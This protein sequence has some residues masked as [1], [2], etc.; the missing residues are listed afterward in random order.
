MSLGLLSTVR[1]GESW[2]DSV[3]A[4]LR[5][6]RPIHDERQILVR[7]TFRHA[8]RRRSSVEVELI[9]DADDD[10]GDETTKTRA[11]DSEASDVEG[12]QKLDTLASSWLGTR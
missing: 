6:H 5:P 12:A 3:R 7:A 11:F 10:G 1:V 2:F 8:H 4:G 9:Q